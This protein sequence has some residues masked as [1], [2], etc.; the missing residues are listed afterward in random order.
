MDRPREALTW[1]KMFLGSKLVHKSWFVCGNLNWIYHKIWWLEIVYNLVTSRPLY[2]YS[3]KRI[4]A[5]QKKRR[6]CRARGC[7]DNFFC[8]YGCF[9]SWEVDFSVAFA[10]NR[11][12][13]SLHC[14]RETFNW[15]A[16]CPPVAWCKTVTFSINCFRSQIY[17][18]LGGLDARKILKTEDLRKD[19]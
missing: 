17:D 16:G 15:F 10:G 13:C 19:L 7:L 2:F 3:V 5:P 11:F 1:W 9:K 8:K 6:V 4:I 12:E 14:W 18:E